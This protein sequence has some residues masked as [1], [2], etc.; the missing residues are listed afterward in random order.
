MI[1]EAGGEGVVNGINGI[2]GVN[3][4]NGAANLWASQSRG[5]VGVGGGSSIS[6]TCQPAPTTTTVWAKVRRSSTHFT[7][8]HILCHAS[9]RLDTVSYPPVPTHHP[10]LTVCKLNHRNARIPPY[11]R[12]L[13]LGTGAVQHDEREL[14]R[15][16]RKQSNRESARRSRLRK[17]AECEELGSRVGGLTE[18]NEKLRG[19]VKRL[20]DQCTALSSDNTKLRE[21]VQAAGGVVDTPAP[22]LPA[23]PTQEVK[24]AAAKAG[25][26]AAAEAMEAAKK[27][28]ALAAGDSEDGDAED[29]DGGMGGGSKDG[30]E[31]DEDDDSK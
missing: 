21:S 16:R 3:G 14:K 29:G 27:A 19:E 22:E 20:L 18:E 12:T 2:N 9:P 8:S 7:M 30:K 6:S 1:A 13:V 28:A 23:G 5:G 31:D 17:Q 10:C 26:A 25:A 4:V 24:E 15:Q 11:V